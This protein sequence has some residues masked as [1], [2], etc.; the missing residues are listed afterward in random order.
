LNFIFVCVVGP[1]AGTISEPSA[2]EVLTSLGRR[3]QRAYKG[4]DAA[5]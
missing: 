3:D 4:G 2:Y 5:T 1:I